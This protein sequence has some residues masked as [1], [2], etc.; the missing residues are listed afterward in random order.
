MSLVFRL[1]A[2]LLLSRI[3][4]TL[5]ADHSNIQ[6]V[7]RKFG[8]VS[9]FLSKIH[10]NLKP[11]VIVK[12]LDMHDIL[13]DNELLKTRELA[14]MR[15]IDRINHDMFDT[16]KAT[17]ENPYDRNIQHYKAQQ[18]AIANATGRALRD[19]QLQLT[20]FVNQLTTE[21]PLA[22]QW[23][24][25]QRHMNEPPTTHASHVIDQKPRQKRAL[26]VLAAVMGIAKLVG[27]MVCHTVLDQVKSA[28]AR[29]NL[30]GA[31]AALVTDST[32]Y[33]RAPD[34]SLDS[35]YNAM[36]TINFED[37]PFKGDKDDYA[38]YYWNNVQHANAIKHT[39][40][41]A[42][43]NM[44][45]MLLNNFRQLMIIRNNQFM[46]DI[47]S[48]QQGK[49]P[50]SL[51]PS[52]ELQHMIDKISKLAELHNMPLQ[53]VEKHTASTYSYYQHITPLLI[54]DK[55]SYRMLL[56]LILPMVPS[57]QQLELYQ[58]RKSVV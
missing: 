24:P 51:L 21:H 30:A 32:N 29:K 3:E 52:G 35:L 2:L 9:T 15:K 57:S 17:S 13:R 41:V 45:L 11:F 22:I 44:E 4:T 47:A 37:R 46:N 18:K 27:P 7:N 34:F 28:I 31:A 33:A 43:I 58:D 42:S 10:F 50:P 5:Q 38:Y 14:V 25:I 40:I 23:S 1:L 12:N 49:I 53:H 56:I 20:H 55:D 39:D 16:Q 36:T 26:P 54:V 19:N 48:I 6:R 8:T